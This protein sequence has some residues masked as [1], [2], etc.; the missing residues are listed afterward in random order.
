MNERTQ[1]L[2]RKAYNLRVASLYMTSTAGS[3]HPTSC[4]SAADIVAT[5]FFYAM[6]YDPQHFNNPN[7]DHFILSKG[8]A[9]P[10]LYAAWKEV[11]I[12]TFEELLTYRS[13]NSVLEGHPTK[14][15]AYT[16]SATGA[17]GIGLSMGVG[18]GLAA[19]LN[20]WQS[21]SYVLMG[22]A[23]IAE[24]SV[25]EAAELACYYELDNVIALV[26]DNRLGQST[27][28]L[29]GRNAQRYAD[30]FAAFGWAT[31]I[32]D[33]HDIPALM[34]ALDTAHNTQG[35]PTVIIAQTFKGYG[36]S[37]AEDV[38]GWHGKALNKEQ[39]EKALQELAQKFP[40]AAAYD[41]AAYSW[42][43]K[44]PP[45]AEPKTGVCA[46]PFVPSAE[47]S[48]VYRGIKETTYTI[49]DMVPTRKAY[50]QALVELGAVCP[51]IVCLDAEVKNSTYAELFEDVYPDRFV[52]CFVAEQNMVSM[53]VGFDRCGNIPFISTFGAFFTRA[54]DQIRMA[55]ISNAR[56]RLVGSHAGVSIGQDGPSQMGLEDIAIMRTLPNSVVLYP[57]DAVSTHKLVYEMAQYTKGISYLRT[58]RMATPVL[59]DTHEKFTIGGCKVLRSSNHDVAC[60]VAAGVTL[61]EALKAYDLLQKEGIHI[62]VIDLYSI[63]PLDAATLIQVGTA[64]NNC[65]ITVEDHYHAGGLG[66]A[67]T[68]ALR[69]TDITVECLAVSALPRSGMPEELLA[70]M[71][72]DARAIV[73]EVKRVV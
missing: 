18:M 58:T 27:E 73:N 9:A 38:L 51:D 5:L 16:E 45:S 44:I 48:K 19:R 65:I 42:K 3:G 64:S 59:Y 53:G 20:T 30:Q 52:Q 61:V 26:D 1:F 70:L 41:E 14:R 57:S 63:K 28:S 33:G 10:L 50:G 13:I 49:G 15:F 68:Y 32:V 4:L 62:A 17:L 6:R 56:L 72:I 39:L 25:W 24:G 22:D 43:P 2:R 46:N 55:A 71:G 47:H 7:N 69:A 31:H 12:L 67:V 54:F 34:Q 40:D 23:E 11:G 60:V 37:F 21:R 8:H 35:Q 36:V 29:H 66:E